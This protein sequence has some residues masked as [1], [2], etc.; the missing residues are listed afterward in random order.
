[1]RLFCSLAA[2]LLASTSRTQAADD[3]P[4]FKITPLR[5]NVSFHARLKAIFECR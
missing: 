3:V 1:M 4:V 5:G 2:I